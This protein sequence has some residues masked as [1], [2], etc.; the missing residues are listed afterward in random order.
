VGEAY[1]LLLGFDLLALH[2][3]GLVEAATLV[4]LYPFAVE[5]GR[6]ARLAAPLFILNI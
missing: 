1:L 5:H 6:L 3:L 2:R 4:A